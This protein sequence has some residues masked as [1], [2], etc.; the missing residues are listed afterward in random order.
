MCANMQGYVHLTNVSLG[1]EHLATGTGSAQADA[2]PT[3]RLKVSEV[4]DD[5]ARVKLSW[6][7]LRFAEG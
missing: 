6:V 2:A 7:S 1:A 4:P 3:G 5:V